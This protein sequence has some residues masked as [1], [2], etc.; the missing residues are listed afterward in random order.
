MSDVA[1]LAM[2]FVVRVVVPVADRMRGER[3]QRKD[4][5]YCK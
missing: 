2:I 4:D 1:N 3:G 5:D